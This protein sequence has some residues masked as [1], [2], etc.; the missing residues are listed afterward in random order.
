M[1][2]PKYQWLLEHVP[3]TLPPKPIDRLGIGGSSWAMIDP[4]HSSIASN[5]LFEDP[6]IDIMEVDA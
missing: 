3:L 2:L 5:T 6:A 1:S 4:R